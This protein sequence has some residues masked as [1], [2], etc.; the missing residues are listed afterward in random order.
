MKTIGQGLKGRL[1]ASNGLR[2]GLRDQR[3]ATIPELMAIIIIA[4]ALAII[5]VPLFTDLR[6]AS[7]A[8]VSNQ[9]ASAFAS[10]M[11]QAKANWMARGSSS[12]AQLNVPGFGNGTLDYS[13]L[14][15]PVG[16][17]V[18][19]TGATSSLPTDAQCREVFQALIPS[20]TVAIPADGYPA[21]G[22][23]YQAQSNGGAWSY[24]TYYKLTPAGSYSGSYFY[25]EIGLPSQAQS[26]GYVVARD[27]VT[28]LDKF[29]VP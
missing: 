7:Q 13:D 3:G 20:A 8:A 27:G 12:G 22:K 28:G 5:A 14:G 18:A 6:N 25:Y 26:R 16:T 21:P 9:T 4:G 29:F 10:T 11:K 24:C 2:A 19:S 17:S 15:Y 23:A 1:A